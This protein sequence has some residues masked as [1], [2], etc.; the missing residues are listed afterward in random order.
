METLEGDLSENENEG[1]GN[2]LTNP[3]R[4]R[5]GLP[6]SN[7]P[8]YLALA[9]NGRLRWRKSANRREAGAYGDAARKKRG[10]CA[11]FPTCDHE[12]AVMNKYY[13]TIPSMIL[14]AQVRKEFPEL[15]VPATLDNAVLLNMVCANWFSTR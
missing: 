10:I 4:I 6:Y 9:A 7:D 12:T 1:D 13:G 2:L 15:F 8:A 14:E 3:R 5:G 11:N